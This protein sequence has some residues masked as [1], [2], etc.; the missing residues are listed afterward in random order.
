[1]CSCFVSRVVHNPLNSLVPREEG[2]NIKYG[3]YIR[4]E[5]RLSLALQ[6]LLSQSA[7]AE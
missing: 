5:L 2:L 6:A 4:K 3:K 1:M 7:A